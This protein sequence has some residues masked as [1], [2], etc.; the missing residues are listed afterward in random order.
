ME[1]TQQE[2]SP[3]DK[4]IHC[5][6][7]GKDFLFTAG[8]Q[9]YYE[10]RGFNPPRR[11]KD[12]RDKRKSEKDSGR[13]ASAGMDSKRE[14]FRVICASCSVETSV[15]FKPDPSRPVFCQRCY[16]Q[17]REDKAGGRTHNE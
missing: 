16:L 9:R 11:C 2:R 5:T 6:D 17:S 14:M 1:A 4:L 3:D 7:C 15:P 12:C 8:E 13:H 10:Q